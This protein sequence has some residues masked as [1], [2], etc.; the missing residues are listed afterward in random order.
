MQAMGPQGNSDRE[1]RHPPSQET[2]AGSTLGRGEIDS[3]SC[4]GFIEPKGGV[5]NQ[6]SD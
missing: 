3:R 5:R 2:R 4:A 6:N 1:D